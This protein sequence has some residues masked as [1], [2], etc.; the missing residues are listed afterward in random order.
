M[1]GTHKILIEYLA[2]S[3]PVLINALP[4][5]SS[6]CS[7]HYLPTESECLSLIPRWFNVGIS[8]FL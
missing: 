7:V 4:D 1:C 6:I 8:L 3:L 5:S 2:I